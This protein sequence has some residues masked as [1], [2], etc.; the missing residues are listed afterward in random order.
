MQQNGQFPE[1]AKVEPIFAQNRGWGKSCT[2]WKINYLITAFAYT[3]WSKQMSL[4]RKVS[5]YSG[6]PIK[7]K[8]FH[9]LAMAISTLSASGSNKSWPIDMNFL[10]A[11]NIRY[12]LLN[13]KKTKQINCKEYTEYLPS[14]FQISINQHL[15]YST[16]TIKT[17]R[18]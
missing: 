13:R 6:W 9:F 2:L 7:N 16:A 3:H 14:I 10:Q 18:I 12:A 4:F 1:W 8:Q 15:K 17:D 5:S 11:S